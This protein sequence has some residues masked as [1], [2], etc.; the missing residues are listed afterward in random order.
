M[1]IPILC[2]SRAFVP[3][4]TLANANIKDIAPTV[5]ALLGVPA[6]QEWEGCSLI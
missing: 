6:A 2:R 4:G 5:T 1:R 3:G